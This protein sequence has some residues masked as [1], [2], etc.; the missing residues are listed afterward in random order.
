MNT[1]ERK[2]MYRQI[3]KHGKDLIDLFGLNKEP[4]KLCKQLRRLEIQANRKMCDFCNGDLSDE[5]LQEY[6]L[7]TLKPA[8][9]RIFGE[10]G[11]QS[12][13]INH[14]PRGYTLKVNETMTAIAHKNK[15]NIHKDWGGY[16]ILAPDFTP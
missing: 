10:I 16:G 15:I 13:Y 4:A 8:L 3:E 11:T 9:V 12:I 5:E 2:E 7:E 14:D 6:I 1:T